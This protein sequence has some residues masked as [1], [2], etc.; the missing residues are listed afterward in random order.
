MKLRD[1][2]MLLLLA[3]FW[4]ASF[5]FIRMASPVLGPVVLMDLRVLIAGGA[6]VFYA[7]SFAR[8][9]ALW[10]R[11]K[12]Y[13][14][15]GAVNAA[16]PF[17]LIAFA[18]LHLP[19]SLAAILNA[20]TPLFA[21]IVATLW[22]HDRL[23]AKKVIGLVVG[24]IGVGILVG[25]SALPLNATLF[26]SVGASLAA[27]GCYGIGGVYSKVAFKGT[28]PLALAIG[29]QLGA[30]LLLFPFAVLKLPTV[31]PSVPVLL[32]VAALAL[33]STS[34]GYLLYFHLMATIG[35]TNTLSVTF[36]VPVFGLLWGALFLGESL[37][38]GWL[39]GLVVILLSLVL[40]TGIRFRLPGAQH[41]PV[42]SPVREQQ[43]ERDR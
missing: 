35:P 33:L 2:G 31:F 28:P 9:P 6:L 17:T 18:E 19:A 20:T 14:L 42:L 27:A 26:L 38:L 1:G 13:L 15:L 34:V 5:L 11:W 16:L 41:L 43:E 39:I 32:A 21:A 3:A 12:A 7:L 30:G 29:Q 37:S 36:L 40:V 24:V 4:G 8:L 22:L 10:S 23:T 25:W